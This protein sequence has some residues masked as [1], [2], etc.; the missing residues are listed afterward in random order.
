MD[1]KLDKD[2][3]PSAVSTDWGAHALQLCTA[4]AC[5]N[6]KSTSDASA[7][8]LYLQ[9]PLP[10]PLPLLHAQSL[11]NVPD[12]VAALQQ[13]MGALEGASAAPGSATGTVS[14]AAAGGDDSATAQRLDALEAGLEVRFASGCARGT[15][16]SS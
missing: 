9:Q 1:S 14:E 16:T 11:L 4:T 3:L 8:W 5:F 2:Q 10:P 7:A 13:R 6:C 12:E 15:P